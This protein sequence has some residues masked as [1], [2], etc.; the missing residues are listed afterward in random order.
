M[1]CVISNAIFY[2]VIIVSFISL[3]VGGLIAD[4][5]L[6]KKIWEIVREDKECSTRE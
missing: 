3:I 5:I 1:V 2:G 4:I 6:C